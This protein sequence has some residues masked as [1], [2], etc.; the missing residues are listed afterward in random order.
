VILVMNFM[1][2]I[3]TAVHSHSYTTGN[4]S[5]SDGAWLLTTLQQA[6]SMQ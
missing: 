1:Y 3:N 4:R 5:K 6:M 2:S